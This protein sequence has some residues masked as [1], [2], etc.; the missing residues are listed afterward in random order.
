M[1]AVVASL[2][3]VKSRVAAKNKFVEKHVKLR[4]KSVP[5]NSLRAEES[6][7]QEVLPDAVSPGEEKEGTG[8]VGEESGEEGGV[9][10]RKKGGVVAGRNKSWKKG[11]SIHF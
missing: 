7:L 4:R 8:Q 9:A 2:L 3:L 11:N 5:N 1:G 6:T 10:G